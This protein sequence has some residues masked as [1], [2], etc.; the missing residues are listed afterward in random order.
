MTSVY[1]VEWDDHDGSRKRRTF[2]TLEDAEAEAAYLATQ[3]DNVMI[4]IMRKTK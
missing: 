3:Y 4:E 2:D 1:I